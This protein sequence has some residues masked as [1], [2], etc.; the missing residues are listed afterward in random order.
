MVDRL[1]QAARNHGFKVSPPYISTACSIYLIGGEYFPF[2]AKGRLLYD[3]SYSPAKCQGDIHRVT[4][5]I[6]EGSPCPYTINQ[7]S[8]FSFREMK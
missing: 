5:L 2:S 7:K 1:A 6:D 8:S 3:M 4:F